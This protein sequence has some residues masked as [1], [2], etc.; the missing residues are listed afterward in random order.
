MRRRDSHDGRGQ[1]GTAMRR[2]DGETGVVS[3]LPVFL[4]PSQMVFYSEQRHSHRAV[5][6]LYNPYNFTISFKSQF[7]SKQGHNAPWWLYKA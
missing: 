6:T 1:G 5:L 7:L 2:A 3:P 4:F